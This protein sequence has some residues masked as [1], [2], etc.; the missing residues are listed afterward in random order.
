[1]AISVQIGDFSLGRP[2][3]GVKITEESTCVFFFPLLPWGVKKKWEVI[4]W[5]FF[6]VAE[7][8]W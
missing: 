7:S 3:G 1:M 5:V 2:Q 4:T 8:M 6:L